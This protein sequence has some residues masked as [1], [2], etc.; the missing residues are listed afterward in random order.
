MLGGCSLAIAAAVIAARA[1]REALT[2]RSPEVSAAPP[3]NSDHFKPRKLFTGS[4]GASI[5]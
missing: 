2:G 3:T 1:A 5:N 4:F